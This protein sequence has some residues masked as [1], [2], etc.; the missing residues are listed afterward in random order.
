MTRRR[1]IIIEEYDEEPVW[2]HVPYQRPLMCAD[3][4]AKAARGE[5]AVCGCYMPERDSPMCSVL[6]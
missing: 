4:A 3:C 5:V 1:I 2:P 6:P